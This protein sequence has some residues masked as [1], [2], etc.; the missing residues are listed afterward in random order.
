[1]VQLVEDHIQVNNKINNNDEI[2]INVP[3]D[4]DDN[5]NDREDTNPLDSIKEPVEVKVIEADGLDGDNGTLE[6]QDIEDINASKE[7]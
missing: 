5:F 6:F 4:E 2:V 1:M 3:L 7:E